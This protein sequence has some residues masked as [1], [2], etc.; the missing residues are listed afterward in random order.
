MAGAA[1]EFAVRLSARDPFSIVA[2]G[3]DAAARV[4]RV[5]FRGDCAGDAPLEAR[6]AD[7]AEPFLTLVERAL[8]SVGVDAAREFRCHADSRGDWAR[9]PPAASAAGGAPSVAPPAVRTHRSLTRRDVLGSAGPW[10]ARDAL[11]APVVWFVCYDFDVPDGPVAWTW[12]APDR[13][14]AAAA[15]AEFE[16]WLDRGPAS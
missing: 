6:G 7:A 11:G 2:F 10:S 1:A 3:H 12:T 8:E 5:H 13:A 9:P 16:A 4:F 15:V 14:A